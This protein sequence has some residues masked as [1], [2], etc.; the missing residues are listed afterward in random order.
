MP[1]CNGHSLVPVCYWKLDDSLLY[2]TTTR[3]LKLLAL[4]TALAIGL[5]LLKDAWQVSS[6][7]PTK[8]DDDTVSYLVWTDTRYRG[9][10]HR[11]SEEPRWEV[12]LPAEAYVWR[13]Y[14]D[15]RPHEEDHRNLHAALSL[16]D[17]SWMSQR[18]QTDAKNVA[19]VQFS[20]RYVPRG[21]PEFQDGHGSSLLGDH[22]YM[23]NFLCHLAKEIETNVFR[24]R[25]RAPEEIE[26]SQNHPHISGGALWD[27]CEPDNGAQ[28]R[29]QIYRDEMQ[30]AG[31]GF[32]E[33]GDKS[34]CHLSI[35]YSVN[36]YVHVK[37]DRDFLHLFPQLDAA[38]ST[39][40]EKSLTED[41][42]IAFFD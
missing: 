5:Y 35:W 25:N 9:S 13:A 32:C 23:V 3:I 12:P 33:T 21:R 18:P 15:K 6:L 10:L 38:V 29:L 24:V 39:V 28:V 26:V 37:I 4:L 2:S 31:R 41:P 27:K 11:F 30:P 8:I 40:T 20:P 1:V 42:S 7:K 22:E 14:E 36:R 19:I 34:E 17:M 16:P